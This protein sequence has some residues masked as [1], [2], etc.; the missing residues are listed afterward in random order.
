MNN[1]DAL[2]I[3]RMQMRWELDQPEAAQVQLYLPSLG[4]L[5]IKMRPLENSNRSLQIANEQVKFAQETRGKGEV[6]LKKK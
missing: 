3:G 1:W 5:I 4:K 2:Q 6:F